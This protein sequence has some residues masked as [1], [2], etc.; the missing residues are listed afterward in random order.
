MTPYYNLNLESV[1][2]LVMYPTMRY[3]RYGICIGYL[4]CDVSE[5]A[6]CSRTYPFLVGILP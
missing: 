2:I 1:T 4:I 5:N 6:N 3:E